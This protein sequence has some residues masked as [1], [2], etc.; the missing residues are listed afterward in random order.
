LVA[1]IEYNKNYYSDGDLKPSE[2]LFFSLT[3]VPFATLNTPD[4]N[5]Q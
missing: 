3:I 5:P 1:A 4:I 2:E